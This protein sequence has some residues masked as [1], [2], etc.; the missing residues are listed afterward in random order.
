MYFSLN[1]LK[2][3]SDLHVYSK[4]MENFVWFLLQLTWYSWWHW[5]VSSMNPILSLSFVVV[6]DGRRWAYQSRLYMHQLCK[7]L[8]RIIEIIVDGFASSKYIVPVLARKP[9]WFG[10]KD[11]LLGFY[12]KWLIQYWN[13]HQYIRNCLTCSFIAFCAP[14]LH[15]FGILVNPWCSQDWLHIL[16][17]VHS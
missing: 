5:R 12:A 13:I 1:Y 15:D 3:E 6:N 7:Q 8:I 17:H 11:V 4:L 9:V 16:L 10:L 14:C 2:L